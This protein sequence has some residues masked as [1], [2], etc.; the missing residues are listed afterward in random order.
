MTD[1]EQDA[2]IWIHQHLVYTMNWFADNPMAG[3]L[4]NWDWLQVEW[5]C[6]C[7]DHVLPDELEEYVECFEPF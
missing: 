4:W 3:D 5:P 7:V 6:G 1:E 2:I